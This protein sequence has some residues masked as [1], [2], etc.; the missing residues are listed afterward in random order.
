MLTNYLTNFSK[1][2]HENEDILA[3]RETCIRCAP[4]ISHC[5]HSCFGFLVASVLGFKA[6]VDPSLACLIAFSEI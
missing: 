5:F 1:K 3:Q 2:L 6:T 4:L